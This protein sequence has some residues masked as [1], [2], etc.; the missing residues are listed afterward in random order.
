MCWTT[1][2]RLWWSGVYRATH[3][4]AFVA[5]RSV[6]SRKIAFVAEPSLLSHKVELV[7]ERSVL[8][9][10]IEEGPTS[11]KYCKY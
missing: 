7:A 5:E 9:H 6:F 8:S 10:A 3:K 2:L 11:R 4:V 1:K